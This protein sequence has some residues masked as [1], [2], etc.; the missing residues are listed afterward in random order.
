MANARYSSVQAFP[1][2]NRSAAFSWDIF[3]NNFP[4]VFPC[5]L[6]NTLILMMHTHSATSRVCN[7]SPHKKSIH[8]SI[9][10]HIV[11][12][13]TAQEDVKPAIGIKIHQCA[14]VT[15]LAVAFINGL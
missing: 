1:T 4:T 14:A 11:A 10:H 15:L 7:E 8:L 3:C 6:R 2:P 12:A 9:P 5:N 13:A